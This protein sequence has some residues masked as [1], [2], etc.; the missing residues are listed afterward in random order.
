MIENIIVAFIVLFASV[1]A[2]ATIYK[3]ISSA[4]KDNGICPSDECSACPNKKKG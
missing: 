2:V 4:R 1:W 3:K